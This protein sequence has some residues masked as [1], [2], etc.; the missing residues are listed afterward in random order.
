MSLERLMDEVEKHL[1]YANSYFGDVRAEIERELKD[2]I[3]KI[4]EL[5][6]EV[7][8]LEEQNMLLEENAELWKKENAILNIELMDLHLQVET[9]KN[10]LDIQK[11]RV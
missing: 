3:E 2:V 5:K 10:E 11:S 6:D 8:T 9:L 7:S 4:T 1:D